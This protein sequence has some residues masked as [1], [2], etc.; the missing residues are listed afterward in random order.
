[1]IQTYS[2]KILHPYAGQV[3]IAES[4]RARALT[5]DGNYWEIQFL[6]GLKSGEKKQSGLDVPHSYVRVAKIK[7]S[8]IEKIAL[9]AFLHDSEI[10][11]R[12]VE[13]ANFIAGVELPFPAMDQYEY[14]L[15]DKVDES[16]LALI[17]SCCEAEQ[18]DTFPDRPEWVALPAAVM[19]IDKTDEEEKSG[20]PPVNYRLERLVAERAGQRPKAAWFKREEGDADR[21]PSLI[22]TEDW[23]EERDS[24]LCDR[25]ITRQ[26]PRLLMLHG[27]THAERLR[28]EQA[29]RKYALEV[30][31]FYPLYPEVADEK[32]MKSILVEE[33]L[34]TSARNE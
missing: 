21:F 30:G 1:M 20:E 4:E 7:H 25:Y 19:K 14:W 28:L 23:E 2:Q 32:L 11:E 17:F 18:M 15:L 16:P 13:L 3:Q 12:I 6:R 27:L 33:R 5:M 29:A 8:E 34:R 10:D 22:V 24:Q 26:A 9:P 31:R